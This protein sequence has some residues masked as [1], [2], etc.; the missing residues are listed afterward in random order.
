MYSSGSMDVRDVVAQWMLS[1]KYK[2]NGVEVVA[3]WIYELWWLNCYREC[4][5]KWM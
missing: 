4:G 5:A 2:G 3:Q 1:I